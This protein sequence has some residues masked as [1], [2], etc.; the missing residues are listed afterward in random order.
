MDDLTKMQQQIVAQKNRN[1]TL[2]FPV[3]DTNGSPLNLTGFKA[4]FTVD[5]KAGVKQF[6]L[7]NTA[8]GGGDTQIKFTNTGGGVLQVYLLP[9][10]TASMTPGPEFLWDLTLEKTD[11]GIITVAGGQFLLVETVT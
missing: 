11:Y 4:T 3:L 6:D 1:L 10:S 7:K 8:A 5:D 2:E 9:A